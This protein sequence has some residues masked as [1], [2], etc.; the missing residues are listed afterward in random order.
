M[1]SNLLIKYK[2]NAMVYR[3]NAGET[4]FRLYDKEV[5]IKMDD[6]TFETMISIMKLCSK[7]AIS[8]HVLEGEFEE[9]LPFKRA[10][11][12]LKEMNMI[13]IIMN[14]QLAAFIN[15]PIY[16]IF[17][18]YAYGESEIAHFFDKIK[19]LKVNLSKSVL[20][21]FPYLSKLMNE[22]NILFK[23]IDN[24]YEFGE[25]TLN[26]TFQNEELYMNSDRGIVILNNLDAFYAY[27]YTTDSEKSYIRDLLGHSTMLSVSKPYEKIIAHY[28]LVYIVKHVLGLGKNLLIVSQEFKFFEKDVVF[29]KYTDTIPLS[30]GSFPVEVENIKQVEQFEKII[31]NNLSFIKPVGKSSQYS[32][33]SQVGYSA[34]AVGFSEEVKIHVSF[35]LDYINNAAEGIK[36]ALKN[37]L[38]NKT[39]QK[40]LVS[41]MQN[42]YYDK[43]QWLLKHVEE[44]IEEVEILEHSIPQRLKAYWNHLCKYGDF[45]LFMKKYLKTGR[46]QCII[47]APKEGTSYEG[48]ITI[49]KFKGLEYVLINSLAYFE[50]QKHEYVPN[51]IILN[52]KKNEDALVS[53]VEWQDLSPDPSEEEFIETSL[54]ILKNQGIKYE[55]DAWIYEGKFREAGLIIRR[56]EVV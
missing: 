22:H 52:N 14:E 35:G 2:N 9:Q 27:R 7:E 28:L 41:D 45:K 25:D 6:S 33:L 39:G 34:Y 17:E 49:S 48:K 26:I 40:W 8:V 55:E 4:L 18:Q 50:N 43:T 15:E 30:A 36:F 19:R 42:Y 11:K 38:E 31:E 53:R 29:D 1:Q 32:Q 54:G 47:R 12:V 13:F 3:L 24:L 51:L 56:V 37:F 23:E 10:L 16:R 21:T 20:S 46:V 44:P 5:T